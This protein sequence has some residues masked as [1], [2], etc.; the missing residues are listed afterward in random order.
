M[1]VSWCVRAL[2]TWAGVYVPA[3]AGVCI[4]GYLLGCA[5][6]VCACVSVHTCRFVHLHTHLYIIYVHTCVHAWTYIYVCVQACPHICLHL[7]IY[8]GMCVCADVHT[9]VPLYM[10][11]VYVY[12]YICLYIRVHRCTGVCI[13]IDIHTQPHADMRVHPPMK[14]LSEMTTSRSSR[15]C[16]SCGC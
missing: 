14:V 5:A 15:P 10:C 2:S 12:M 4:H 8:T 13:H 9:R 7:Y 3:C 6:H 1:C 16:G 11:T